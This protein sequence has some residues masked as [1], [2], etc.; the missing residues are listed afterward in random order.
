MCS[1][2]N[3]T[4]LEIQFPMLVMIDKHTYNVYICKHKNTCHACKTKVIL[5]IAEIFN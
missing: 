3:Y 2:C 5:T 1:M 4:N